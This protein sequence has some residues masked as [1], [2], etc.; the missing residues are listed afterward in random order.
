MTRLLTD[1]DLVNFDL[2][3]RKVINKTQLI[4]STAY[5]LHNAGVLSV[6]EYRAIVSSAANV[7]E[8]VYDLMGAVFDASVL[9]G[10]LQEKRND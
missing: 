10:Q 7:S 1:Q 9:G 5:T 6:K 2:E 3:S 8:Q 4:N